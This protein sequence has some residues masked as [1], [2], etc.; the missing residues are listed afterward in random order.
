MSIAQH[1][2]TPGSEIPASYGTLKTV[3]LVGPPNSGKTTL[4]NQLT[5]LHQ[6]VA[7]F[8]GVTV[9]HHTGLADLTDGRA[10]RIIDL[11]G[12]YSMAARSEDERVSYEVLTGQRA[13]TPKPDAILLVLDS[14]NLTR[15]LMLAAPI[16]ALGTPTL[17][18]LNMADDLHDRSGKLDLDALSRELGTQVV[19]VAARSG[20]GMEQVRDF[21]T[22]A[23]PAPTPVFLPVL[24]DVP[25]CREWAG[26][27]GL[28]AAYRPP[29]PPIWT[30]RLDDV[31]LHPVAGPAVFCLVVIAV[32]QTIFTA[33]TPLMDGVGWLF[34]RSGDWIAAT[35]TIPWLRSLLVEGIWSGVG[36]VVKFLPQI[37]LLFL[38]IGILEDSG[39]L[40]R[41]ALIADRTMARFG[42]QGK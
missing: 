42:L 24:K 5:G 23:M 21:L 1:C 10:V 9:D 17:V 16:L 32:F 19:L 8:P 30:R 28:S 15:H 13:D 2:D 3:V 39:Y 26:S 36:S 37:L 31:F 35:V 41:A 11:P 7:N 33:A 22:S 27:I 6:K 12:I 25:K 38:F 34:D 40:A 4:F 20:A 18:I 29:I 14:T